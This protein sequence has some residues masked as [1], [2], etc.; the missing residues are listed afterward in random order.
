MCG[1]DS[2]AAPAKFAALVLWRRS[3]SVL[4]RH[5]RLRAAA[6]AIFGTR[7]PPQNAALKLLLLLSSAH[8]IHRATDVAPVVAGTGSEVKTIKKNDLRYFIYSL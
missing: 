1:I 3:F 8:P 5:R 4:A 2:A 6:A 7:A